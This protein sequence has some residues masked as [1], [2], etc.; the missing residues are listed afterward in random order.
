METVEERSQEPAQ[1]YQS[2]A[3][4][5]FATVP[6][7]P[8]VDDAVL[9][10]V[11][12]VPQAPDTITEWSTYPAFVGARAVEIAGENLNRTRLW[13]RN[14]NAAGGD[15]VALVPD[16]STPREF[17]YALEAQDTVEFFHNRRVWAQC[18]TGDT[19]T[20][21]VIVEYVVTE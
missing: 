1:D 15:T 4:T 10:H 18:A 20:L 17:G 11:V 12:N 5:G 7:P 19:A 14:G 16:G 21:Y 13:I 9:V 3:D 6:P 8:D 2:S